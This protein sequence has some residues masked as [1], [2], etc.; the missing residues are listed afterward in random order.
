MT[1]IRKQE[2]PVPRAQGVKSV[3]VKNFMGCVKKSA[4][5]NW[6]NILK[7]NKLIDGSSGVCPLGPSKKV[8]AAVRKAVKKINSGQ[9][10]G[11][12]A[13]T[14]LFESKF[15]L[16]SEKVLFANSIKELIYLIPEVLRPARVLVVG[17]ALDIYEDAAQSAGAEVSYITAMETD[18]FAFDIS[19]IWK[20]FQNMDLVFIANPNRI[21]GKMIPW[22]KIREAITVTPSECPHFV[23]DESLIEF[24]GSGDYCHDLIHTKKITLLRTT[25]YFY[26][27][28]RLELAC[29]V[30]SPEFIQLY[31]KNAR[32]DINLLSIEA[33]RTAYKDS[34]YGKAARQFTA[35][36]KKLILRMLA[37][38][39]WVRVYDT[40]TNVILIKI[41]NK[42]SG[43]AAQQFKRAGLDIRDC[44]EIK[45]MDR[46]FF[47]ISVMKHENNL[48][49][50]SA[51][52]SLNRVMP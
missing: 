43:I 3:F 6:G 44:S 9:H 24:T 35:L 29:A 33:A 32:W 26:G 17:P 31:K 1:Q 28:S 37:K 20:D 15:R 50:I 18:G 45:G 39:E 8:K 38:I 21:T 13:L 41:I 36:E 16:S 10:M 34:T 11:M 5:E 23:I 7:D 12:D 30:S 27:V 19:C 47:R 22:E 52:N 25:A 42:N 49:L 2:R 14:R 46:S 48:K 40:D 51:L 4:I